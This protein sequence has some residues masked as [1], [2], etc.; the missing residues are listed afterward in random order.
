M[1]SDIRAPIQISSV[2]DGTVIFGNTL[3]IDPK[4]TAK[5]YLG[6]AAG[7]IGD[8][9]QTISYKSSTNTYDVD[10][11]EEVAPSERLW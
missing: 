3:V 9:I 8:N 2:G 7:N 1:A 11:F 5:S 6:A 10:A 4:S